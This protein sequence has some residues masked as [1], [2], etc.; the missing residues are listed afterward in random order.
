MHD[1]FDSSRIDIPESWE[2]SFRAIERREPRRVLV[3]GPSDS[4]KSTYCRS[5]LRRLL[6]AGGAAALVDA[7]IG[8][9]D[10][11]PPG[12]IT[13]AL[14]APSAPPWS[15][16]HEGL[17]FIGA[18]SPAG[19]FTLMAEG[20]RSMVED[21]ETRLSAPRTLVINT[22]GFIHGPGRALKRLK[23]LAAA[24]DVIVGMGDDP[25][26]EAIMEEHAD[27]IHIRVNISMRAASKTSVARREARQKAFQKYF[28]AA[29]NVLLRTDRVD[30][31]HL[32]AATEEW[33]PDRQGARADWESSVTD[34]LRTL[35]PG[36]ERG[37]LCG[38]IGA[39]GMCLGLGVIQRIDGEAGGILLTTPVPAKEITALQFGSIRV[40]LP[41]HREMDSHAR[42]KAGSKRRGVHPRSR[43][44]PE[45][46]A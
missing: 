22:T 10:A 28:G 45:G 6:H 1:I 44:I 31:Q 37:I 40:D 33:S 46:E 5:L 21:A 3:I 41:G 36:F 15:M 25:D 9:K 20:V 14:P 26:V 7:D 43:G 23:I 13:W 16:T 38:A 2:D 18:V 32:S 11:G 17:F 12:A 8:Q 39:R 24:P 35:P 27:A 42:R 19:R 29:R 34:D 30:M 4:G